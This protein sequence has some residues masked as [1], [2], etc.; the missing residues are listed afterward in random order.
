VVPGATRVSMRVCQ[1]VRSEGVCGRGRL[2]ACWR[3]REREGGL[4]EWRCGV[5]RRLVV[6]DSIDDEAQMVETDCISRSWKVLK[7]F[8]RVLSGVSMDGVGVRIVAVPGD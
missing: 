1:A 3:I 6:S 2:R 5:V 7:R 4:S 8:E